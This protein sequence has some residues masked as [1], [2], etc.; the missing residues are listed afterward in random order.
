VTRR[1]NAEELRAVCE[2]PSLPF[3]STADEGLA[4]LCGREAGERGADGRFPAGSI[5]AAVEA[6]LEQ[7][8]ERLRKQG[9]GASAG[10]PHAE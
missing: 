6:A 3:R 9:A 2:P 8:A 5:N 10:A 4:R 1:L 7:N